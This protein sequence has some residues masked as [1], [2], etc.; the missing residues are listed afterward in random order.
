MIE[1]AASIGALMQAH[2]GRSA[3][4][5]SSK[6]ALSYIALAIYGVVGLVYLVG[7]PLFVPFHWLVPLWIGWLV[8]LWVTN[9]LVRRRSW[10]AL[11]AAPVA[12]VVLWAYAEAGWAMWD[13]AVED[14]PL[15]SR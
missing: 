12:L 1:P 13:W 6:T 7:G 9:R 11:A 3:K 5:E 4:A 15:R 8:G 2:A 14:L 10:W